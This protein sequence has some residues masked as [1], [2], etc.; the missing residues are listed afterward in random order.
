MVI[1]L[2]EPEKGRVVPAGSTFRIRWNAK[3]EATRFRVLYS[4]N[5]GSSWKIVHPERKFV[6]GLSYDWEVRTPSKTKKNCLI[7][8]IAYDEEGT[9]LGSDSSDKPFTI[10]VP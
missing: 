3:P 6:T 4:L 9:K 5:K 7:K 1:H 10:Q 8:I 2:I